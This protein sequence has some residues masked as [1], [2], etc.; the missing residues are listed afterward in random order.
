MVSK[1][2]IA[3]ARERELVDFMRWNSFRREALRSTPSWDSW[4]CSKAGIGE[5]ARG[6]LLV[7]VC[8]RADGQRRSLKFY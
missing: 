8:V 6:W 7:P 3:A 2:A 4:R 1:F 5:L